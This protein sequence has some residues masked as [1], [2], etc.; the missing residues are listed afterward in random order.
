MFARPCVQE[1]SVTCSRRRLASGVLATVAWLCVMVDQSREGS[2][3][4][5]QRPSSISRAKSRLRAGP[6]QTQLVWSSHCQ[7]LKPSFCRNSYADRRSGNSIL[8]E[9]CMVSSSTR[10]VINPSFKATLSPLEGVPAPLSEEEDVRVHRPF[11]GIH[12]GQ[13]AVLAAIDHALY[14]AVQDHPGTELAGRG[15]GER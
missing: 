13:R 9:I 5:M 15:V 8:S 6:H 7:S 11:T 2:G 10:L 3:A 4:M 14:A 12:R 1:G